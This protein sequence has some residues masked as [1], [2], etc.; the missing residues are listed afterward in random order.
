MKSR[1]IYILALLVLLTVKAGAQQS[2]PTPTSGSSSSAANTQGAAA[3]EG[4]VTVGNYDVISSI[5][6]G[7]RAAEVNGDH[8]LY[9]SQLNYQPGFR[10]FDSS[11]LMRA[12]KGA[13]GTFFDTFLVN[14]T[15]FGADP[16]GSLRISAQKDHWYRFDGS[17]R[18]NAYDSRLRNFAL[19]EHRWQ[20][21][22]KFSDFDLKLLPLNKKIRFNLGYSFDRNAGL[23]NTTW[24]YSGDEYPVLENYRSRANEYRMGVEANVGG[25]D[26]NFLQ[27][28]R[29]YKEDSNFF[30][31]GLN[32][33]NNATDT[34][35]LSGFAR[36]QPTRSRVAFSRFGLHT[37]IAKS[38]DIGRQYYR[39]RPVSFP[40]TRRETEPPVRSRHDVGCQSKTQ[41]FRYHP[42]LQV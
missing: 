4:A 20:T 39:Q 6:L 34:S 23:V 29:Y 1:T 18:R 42:P 26:L 41:D 21:K 38:F 17:F 14:S 2:S 30:I 32:Q 37:L 8:D 22:H 25:V 27:G 36:S 40:R 35:N 10:V 19:N 7:V 31:T 28:F 12:R 5:E 3:G 13:G 16:A 9:R 11:F 15:G 24:D 33:G